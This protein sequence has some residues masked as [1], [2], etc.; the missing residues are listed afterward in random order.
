MSPLANAVFAVLL[1]LSPL[2]APRVAFPGWAE[3][4]ND[5]AWRYA[6]IASDIAEAATDACGERGPVCRRWAAA[7]LI[8]IGWHESGWSADVDIGPCYRGRDGKS[9]RCDGG[10]SRSAWQLRGSAEERAVWSDRKAAAREALRRAWRSLNACRALPVAWRLSAYSGGR[11]VSE[12]RAAAAS[13][14]LAAA[15]KRAEMAWP[16]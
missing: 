14:E 12:G 7:T 2:E 4:P 1:H 5:R 10:N 6:S 3:S 11:C 8:G 9:P 15:V 16:Q 13:G